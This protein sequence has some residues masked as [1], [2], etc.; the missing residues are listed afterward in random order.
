[1]RLNTAFIEMVRQ[2]YK[3][4]SPAER[5]LA[6][7]VAYRQ[8]QGL[9]QKFPAGPGNHDEKTLEY[10]VEKLVVVFGLI[11]QQNALR[12]RRNAIEFIKQDYPAGE[13]DEIVR[14][15]DLLTMKRPGQDWIM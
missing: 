15:Y 6:T 9:D 1:M 11:A 2:S 10:E 8:T 5:T 12:D 13:V 4:G 7:V 3:P 14:E